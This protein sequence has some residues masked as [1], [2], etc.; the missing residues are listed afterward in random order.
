VILVGQPQLNEILDHPEMV[1]LTQRVKLRYHIR[2]LSEQELV[3]YIRHRLGMAGAPNRTL[4][5]PESLPL[6]YKYAGGIPRLTNTLC[7]AVL[8]CACADSLPEITAE[9]VEAAARE[10]QWPPYAQRVDER[11]LKAMRGPGEDGV[12][13]V[14]REHSQALAALAARVSKI[15]GMSPA[16]ESIGKRL[17]AIETQLR[18]LAQ[19]HNVQPRP[20]S[21]V[22]RRQRSG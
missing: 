6:I 13:G 2:A 18:N 19:S 9:V 21:T 1:Q 14:L 10:L 8:T 17:E 5:L 15:E 22:N 20:D 7:D 11:N 4:F 16:L 3:D 12:E